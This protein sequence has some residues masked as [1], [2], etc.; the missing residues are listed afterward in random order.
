VMKH[1]AR[2]P[3]DAHVAICE[4]VEMFKETEKVHGTPWE[5]PP[6]EWFWDEETDE[7]KSQG[8]E[9][10]EHPADL[11]GPPTAAH[12]R[13]P[14]R[15]HGQPQ[16]DPAEGDV[17]EPEDPEVNVHT[18]TATDWPS[19]VAMEHVSRPT[20]PRAH[21]TPS[22]PPIVIRCVKAQP[23]LPYPP[24]HP[25]CSPHD[26]SPMSLPHPTS[27]IPVSHAS[28]P[29]LT[30]TPGDREV[31]VGLTPR[32]GQPSGDPPRPIPESQVG[33]GRRPYRQ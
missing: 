12:P 25:P 16:E 3:A 5:E 27:A 23:C 30:P 14:V 4:I 15:A 20:S 21:S 29:H 13:Y 32:P 17:D 2:H 8:D 10:Q 22:P 1:L 19:A 33:R 11:S 24:A 31:Q 26:M 9:D 7:F 18:V 28:F 6:T